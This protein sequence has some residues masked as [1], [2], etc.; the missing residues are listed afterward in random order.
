MRRRCDVLLDCDVVL[1]RAGLSSIA[2]APSCIA[3]LP[4]LLLACGV[5]ATTYT[6][7]SEAGHLSVESIIALHQEEVWS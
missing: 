6:A 3:P 5:S 2:L 1:D 7:Q 4:T